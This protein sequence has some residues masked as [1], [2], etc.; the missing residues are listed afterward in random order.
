LQK[1]SLTKV[2]VRF[3]PTLKLTEVKAS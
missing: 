1:P 2:D 3:L